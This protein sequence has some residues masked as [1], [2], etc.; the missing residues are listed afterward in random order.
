MQKMRKNKGITLIALIITI[1]ILLILTAVSMTMLLGENGLITKAIQSGEQMQIA[2]GKE[3][4]DLQVLGMI[5]EKAS[6]SESCTLEYIK[7]NLPSKLQNL[8]IVGE[9]G[10]PLSAFYVEYKGYEYEV[11]AQYIVTY[12]GK[13]DYKEKPDISLSIDQIQTGVEK[14]T[15]EA[16]ASVEEGSIEEIQM[17]DGSKVPGNT[18]SLEVKE[19]GDYTFTATSN[20]G[21]VTSKTINVSNIRQEGMD[22]TGLLTGEDAHNHIYETQYN[23]TQH[24]EEC[25]IC[26]NKQNIANHHIQTIG[27]AATCDE[28]VILGQE[29]CTDNCGYSKQLE[30]L[31]H[32]R[33]AK[34]NWQNY[35]GTRH[36]AYQCE[37]CGGSG[38]NSLTQEH[39]F[40]INGKIMTV[41]QMKQAGM[42]IHQYTSLTCT[43]CK[44]NIPLNQH[45]FYT[46]ICYLCDKK[47]GPDINFNI[48]EN[49]VENGQGKIDLLNNATQY[50]YAQVNTNGRTFS[51]VTTSSLNKNT[52]YNVGTPELIKQEGN[53]WTYRIPI[54]L[55]DRNKSFTE[56][57]SLT[58]YWYTN[59]TQGSM[60]DGYVIGNGASSVRAEA[61]LEC[62][63]IHSQPTINEIKEIDEET[64]GEWVIK[65]KLNIQGTATKREIVYISMYDEEGKAI[66]EDEAV[67]VVNGNY[68]FISNY[69][70]EAIENTNFT[71]KVKDAFGNIGE[72][73]ITL[74][75]VD[76]QAPTI[77]S[78]KAFNEEWSKNKEVKLEIEEK[79]IGGVQIACN[80][81][82]AYENTEQQEGKYSKTYNFIG[83]I[84]QDMQVAIYLKDDLGNIHTEKITI[85]KIDGT[86]PTITNIKT[87]KEGENTKV[88]IEANDRNEKLGEEG[89]GIAGYAIT[90]SKELPIDAL[91]SKS[92]TITV[93]SPGTYYIYV[94]DNAGNLANRQEIIIE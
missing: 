4:I 59:L 29:V 93:T 28:Y 68:S 12:V 22:L 11:N 30:Y 61:I 54:S 33:P 8:G 49:T 63:P 70:L 94:K 80:D 31:E 19:N 89:S 13:G 38:K 91:Y 52:N 64:V 16:I 88:T 50:V 55:I 25:I 41:N 57:L 42:N 83:D 40:Y 5:T 90:T 23:D 51:S 65:K 75:H 73:Q 9:K 71:I 92:A 34:L 36:I 44:L 84:Y 48:A 58:M 66:F 62:I 3:E 7:E 20:R 67:P 14:V 21:R 53:I 39:T 69:G 76:S 74:S 85:G 79:G 32:I 56:T 26:G 87:E 24:W 37:R 15:I 86:S 47:Y 60:L 77:I 18:A 1:V 81:A 27:N 45:T 43:V 72:K 2:S 17:P 82:N 78:E 10:S 46:N 6:K 35:L